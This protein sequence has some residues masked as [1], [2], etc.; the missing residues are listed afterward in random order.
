MHSFI[1]NTQLFVDVDGD[2]DCSLE[3]VM[4]FFTGSNC[5]PPIGFEERPIL[6]F[7]LGRLATSS[8]CALRLQ[9]PS[10]CNIYNEFKDAL[11][12]S[13]KGNDGFEGV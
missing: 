13:F 4:V 12:L 9:I 10:I 7:T 8:T 2:V 5:V 3:D 11:I 6:S 1:L